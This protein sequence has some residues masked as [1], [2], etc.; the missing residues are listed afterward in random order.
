[1]TH[2]DLI[3]RILGGEVVL[4]G[5]YRGSR[6][7]PHRFVDQNSGEVVGSDRLQHRLECGDGIGS[8]LALISEPAPKD[9]TLGVASGCRKGQICA[10][11]ISW[12]KREREQILGWC[13]GQPAHELSDP[14]PLSHLIT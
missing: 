11:F 12:L 13:S 5:E 6:Q 7:L 9:G 14:A 8:Q 4:V 3:Q 10:F 1:M 2:A